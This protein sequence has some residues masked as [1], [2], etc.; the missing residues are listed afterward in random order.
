MDS[1]GII[2]DENA[3]YGEGDEPFTPRTLD[4]QDPDQDFYTEDDVFAF[5]K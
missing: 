5:S 2:T 4:G 1:L 3:F